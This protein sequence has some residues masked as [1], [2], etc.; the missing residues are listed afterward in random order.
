MS[1]NINNNNVKKKNSVFEDILSTVTRYFL[2][3]VVVVVVLIALSGIRIVKSGNVAIVLRF[4]KLVGNTYEDQIHEP[5]LMFAFPYII[6]EVIM[7]PTGNVIEQTVMTHYTA[8]EMTTMRNNGYVITGDRNIAVMAVSVK[9]NITDAVT[10]AL[11]VANIDKI[12]NASVSNAMVESAA[13]IS[14]DSLLTTGK[15]D[16]AR[17]VKQ[18]SQ[19]TLDTAKTGITISTVEL[20]NVSMPAEV[21]ETYDLV[22]SATVQAAT[23]LEQAKQYRE[24]LI[25]QAEATANSLISEANA[26]Y[27]TTLA[28]ARSDLSEFNGLLEEYKTNP[29]VVRTRVYTSKVSE[30]LAKIGKIRVVQDG[31]SKIIIN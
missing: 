10:Y 29:G 2:I 20:T 22:N 21:K 15:E 4:G 13:H 17:E 23:M 30:A 28:D 11:N 19:N 7:V 1:N 24:N 5:G 26:R 18:T 12:I 3:L 8:T 16:F 25:P 6:D 31:E 9:Y 27:S 14:V